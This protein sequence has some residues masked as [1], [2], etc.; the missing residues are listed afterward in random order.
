[1]YA[2][3][4][5]LV[6]INDTIEYDDGVTCRQQGIFR[7]GKEELIDAERSAVNVF[8]NPA[9]TWL[10]CVFDADREWPVQAVIVNA[11][12]KRVYGAQYE[13]NSGVI[14]ISVSSLPEGLY[15]LLL[16]D[17]TGRTSTHKWSKV[18]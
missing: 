17:R 9:S 12:G 1:V 13:G 7:L 4:T 2:A 8:P 3:R 18:R 11:E 6:A 15:L 14:R 10:Q 16:Q 5:L